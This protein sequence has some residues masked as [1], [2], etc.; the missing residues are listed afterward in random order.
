MAP[1]THMNDRLPRPPYDPAI[2]AALVGLGH[3][4]DRYEV[5]KVRKVSACRT[6]PLTDALLADKS[7]SI[8]DIVIPGPSG[9]L[10]V[11]VVRPMTEAPAKRLRP[12]I[13]YIHGG[14][15]ISCNRFAGLD[16]SAVWARDLGAITVS[17]EY[18]LA[19]E[20]TG[21]KPARDCYAAL[22][23]T[24]ANLDRLGVDPDRLV[25][26]GTSAGGGLAAATALLDRDN[27]N[28]GTGA[29]VGPRLCGLF[30]E[31]PMLD[32]R[33]KTV[34]AQQYTSGPFYNSTMN[35][36]AWRCL[37]GDRAGT[38]NVSQYEVPA[39]AAD[40]SGLPPTFIDCASAEPFRD[41]IVDFASRLWAAGVAAE[42][43]VWPGG[44]HGY[45][46]IVPD[47]PMSKQ[48]REARLAWLRK[49]FTT[50]V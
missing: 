14:A 30:L 6:R 1:I 44:P 16:T 23:W 8:E 36:F 2:E 45:D 40:L 7:V 20:S 15:L 35:R 50:G 38:D 47:A 24:K 25:L 19:P 43:H 34:S 27:E 21:E 12:C 26:Y 18:G 13:F 3:G 32:D 46:R 31:C 17:V 28:K 29:G 22:L 9:S 41:D 49:A 10:T 5:E 11:S 39:R 42:L 37:L 33:N 48:A 4:P